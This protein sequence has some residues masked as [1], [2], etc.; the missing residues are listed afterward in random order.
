[1]PE[2]I[3]GTFHL[4]RKKSKML[5]LPAKRN[6]DFVPFYLN[7][8]IS[9]RSG[10]LMVESQGMHHFVQN[11]S[12]LPT[13]RASK[14][15]FMWAVTRTSK[16]N[17]WRA[18]WGSD[19]FRKTPLW[20]GPLG[21]TSISVSLMDQSNKLVFLKE[22]LPEQFAPHCLIS[23]IQSMSEG[24]LAWNFRFAKFSSSSKARAISPLSSSV[25]SQ[26]KYTELWS[27]NQS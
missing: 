22:W 13:Y 15:D 8:L 1:M 17:H 6:L 12:F 10:H 2:K 20:T 21:G 7:I 4:R 23:V 24:V 14:L 3:V 5:K 19:S 26:L 16:T 18:A 11:H 27:I 25:Q 9:V